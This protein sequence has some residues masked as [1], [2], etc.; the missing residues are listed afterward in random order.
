MSRSATRTYSKGEKITRDVLEK[1]FELEFPN[2]RPPFNVNPLTGHQLELDCYNEE[3]GLAVEVNGRQH[4]EYV[5]RFH[6]DPIGFFYQQFKDEIKEFQCEVND[7]VF[8]TVPY[9]IEEE[10]I[11][12]Y[13]IALLINTRFVAD[14]AK[15]IDEYYGLD[16]LTNDVLKAIATNMGISGGKTKSEIVANIRRE[17]NNINF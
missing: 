11:E 6:K 4:Y 16:I 17:L 13:I 14:A 5:K 15:Y 8:L 2:K 9:T 12:P 7:I 3:L 1:I 10:D